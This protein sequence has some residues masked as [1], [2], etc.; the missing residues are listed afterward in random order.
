MK[1]TSA[2]DVL[3]VVVK[4]RVRYVVTFAPA[5]GSADPRPA[6]MALVHRTAAGNPGRFREV[7]SFPLSVDYVQY[8]VRPR[9]TVTVWEYLPDLPP[10]PDE[11]PAVVPTAGLVLK[12]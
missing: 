1:G 11:L 5:D 3:D 7:D 9:G 12:P 6:E 8:T 10:G 4:G 2:A